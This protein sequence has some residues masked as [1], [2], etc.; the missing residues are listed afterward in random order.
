MSRAINDA[1][2]D[3]GARGPLRA[4]IERLRARLEEAEQTLEAIRSGDVDALVVSGPEGEQIFSLSSAETV[5][6]R[7]FETMAEAALNV[8]PDGTILF[9]NTRFAELIET[10]MAKVLG[11]DLAEWIFPAERDEFQAL[12]RRC[13][14]QP[15]KQRVVFRT[16]GG[17]LK[18]IHVTGYALEQPG[19]PSVCLVGTDLTELENSAQHIVELQQSHSTVLKLMEEAEAARREAE[20]SAAAL[21]ESEERLSLAQ[22]AAQVGIWDWRIPADETTFNDE[23]YALYGLPQGTQHSYADFL[24]LVHPE[25]RAGVDAALQAA[26]RGEGPYAAEYRIVR[27]D[28]GAV[29][30]FTARG[31]VTFTEGRPER[32]FGTVYDITDRK[33]AE[34]ALQESET[35]M[36]QAL[37]VSHSYTFDWNPA[38]DHVVRSASCG[39]VLRLSGD[40][41]IRDSG[42]AYFQRVHPDDRERFI[43]TLRALKPDSNSYVTEYRVRCGDGSVAVVE[44]VAQASFNA[45]GD[46]IRLVGVATDI[47][48]RKQAEE[49]LKEADRRKDEFLATLAH[50]LR[51]PLAPIRNALHVLKKTDDQNPASRER[52][53][54][55]LV[56]VERQVKH[57]V[58]LVDDLLEV[59]RIT[60]GKI[61][62]RKER[63]DLGTVISHALDTSRA[64]IDA[65][66]H[67]L[68]VSLPPEPFLIEADA[69][70]L[71]QVFANL[72]NNA[73]KYTE[74]GGTIRVGVEQQGHEA[75]VSVRDT[76]IGIPA[77][78]LPKVFDVFTQAERSID[79]SQGGLGIGLSLVR[80][81]VAMHGGTV[82]AR[83]EG[84]GRGSEFEVRL[85]L[86][87]Y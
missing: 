55:L 65:G 67:G 56:M 25:D 60:Q 85:P 86:A 57:L 39:A 19:G 21:R 15:V 84:P 9:C 61:E 76:G 2:R 51:N 44:E 40:K 31:R 24:A 64:L 26:L 4:E 48:E 59:S 8:T 70:R 22:W 27:A 73:A 52:T 36:Q 5:Y 28:T 43:Q 50:E 54:S 35:R 53:R 66:H 72:L 13:E 79:R 3:I 41:A 78:M 33:R 80:H 10:P 47:T 58:R 30:W 69:V 12:L 32:A 6:R 87:A 77:E 14:Q 74:P 11:R 18:A 37:W 46:M 29:R 62:L 63:V 81:L 7:V 83:S 82:T 75:V 1:A 49:A 20:R 71:T 17:A 45:R 34:V 16:A 42:Q 38:T 68:E 23:Y